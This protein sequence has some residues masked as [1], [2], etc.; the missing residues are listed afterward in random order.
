MRGYDSKKANQGKGGLPYLLAVA[1]GDCPADLALRNARVLDLVTGAVHHTDIA[2]VGKTIAAVRTGL[3]ARHSFDMHG[4][5]VSPGLVDAHVHVESSMLRPREFARLIAPHG[6]TT[7]ISNPHE[8]ANVCGV[9]GIRCMCDDGRRSLVDILMTVPSCVPATSLA[10]AG[11]SLES[12]DLRR[13]LRY[14]GVV[15]L[16]E[17]MDF[18]GV[19]HGHPRLMHELGLAKGWLIDGHAPGVAGADLDAYAAAGISSDHECSTAQEALARLRRGMRVFLREGSAARNL[20]ALLPVISPQYER[21]LA[22]CTDDR[23]AAD[24]LHEGS[25]DHLVRMAMA[26]GVPLVT[27]LRMACLNP[28]EHYR[29]TDRGLIA[30]GKRADIVAFSSLSDFRPRLVWQAGRLVARDGDAVACGAD[31]DNTS[32]MSAFLDTVHVDWTSIDLR[33]PAQTQNVRVI[34]VLKG[35]LVTEQRILSGKV[36]NGELMADPARDILKLAVIERH[37]A[38]GRCGKG[39]VQGLQLQ[40]GAVA[41]TVAHD[42]HNL[43]VAGSDDRSMMTAARAVADSG[44]GQAV[45]L[46]DR[47]LEHVALPLGGLMSLATAGDL[48]QMQSRLEAAVLKLGC[49]L[50]RLFMTLS[51]LALEVIPELKL[52]DYGLVDVAAQKVVPLCVDA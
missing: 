42:H 12:E 16:G 22:F 6:V 21:W 8:I 10:G 52:T 41:S 19:I 36:Q 1:R 45:A 14:P 31:R 33:I 47:V 51:F 29:L 26:D 20:Q 24:L 34:G 11:A 3:P 23:D 30:P 44:G 25:I 46:G 49:G 37:Q 9:P 13:L 4:L 7:A 18:Q 15:G 40:Q 28:A 39:F 17:V 50:P 2:I 48:I 5:Y 35:Q 38:S 43:I 27:A 32:C